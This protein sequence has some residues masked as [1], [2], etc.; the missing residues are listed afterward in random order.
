MDLE[1]P[2]RSVLR[3]AGE[4]RLFVSFLGL[5]NFVFFFFNIV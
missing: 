4:L 3:L 5:W 2:G 1:E